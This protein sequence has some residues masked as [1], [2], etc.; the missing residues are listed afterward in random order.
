MKNLLKLIILIILTSTLRVSAQVDSTDI[1]NM[2]LKDH[3]LHVIEN[4]SEIEDNLNFPN[5]FYVEQEWFGEDTIHVEIEGV[6]IELLTKDEISE[7]VS[8]TKSIRL[9]SVRPIFPRN[10]NMRTLVYEFV[11]SSDGE[12]L[13][14]EEIR[15]VSYNWKLRSDEHEFQF[16]RMNE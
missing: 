11:V 13:N 6:K 4:N 2:I 9:F 5:H 7:K 10:E 12:N 15:H 16:E 3:I 14:Y 8:T 1:Y